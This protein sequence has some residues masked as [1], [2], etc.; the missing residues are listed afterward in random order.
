MTFK[1]QGQIYESMK[2]K[3]ETTF[4]FAAGRIFQGIMRVVA[5]GISIA[6]IALEYVYWNIFATYADRESLRRMYEDWNVAWD[7][8]T[9]DNARKTVLNKL[10]QKGT[11]TSQ[12][13]EDACTLNFDEVTEATAV[14]GARGLGTVDVTVTYHHLPVSEDVIEDIQ[15]FFDS[16]DNDVVCCDVLVKTSGGN[17]S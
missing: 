3:F 7:N 6:Y 16:E 2:D 11:G 14:I 8:P 4:G 1:T 15:A 5:A 17:I 9:T 10:R 12:W 13:F